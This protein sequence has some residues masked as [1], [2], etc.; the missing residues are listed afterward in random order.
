[1]RRCTEPGCITILTSHNPGSRCFVHA[2]PVY[3]V[4]EHLPPV[5]QI[6]PRP[7]STC[8]RLHRNRT[9]LGRVAGRCRDCAKWARSFEVA[10]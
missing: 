8:G 6:K 7:C 10:R 4:S 5:Q 2:P 1:M 9:K 3:L